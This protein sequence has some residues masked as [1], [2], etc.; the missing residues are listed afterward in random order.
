MK[1]YF[2]PAFYEDIR[3]SINCSQGYVFSTILK[4]WF[5]ETHLVYLLSSD[6]ERERERE[7]ERDM[8]VD[9]AISLLF[10]LLEQISRLR[11]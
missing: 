9:R 1:I 10:P 4:Y 3:S 2:N 11:M 7:R 6:R 5:L 8:C